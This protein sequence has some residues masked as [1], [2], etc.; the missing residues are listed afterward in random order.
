MKLESTGILINLRPFNENDSIACVFSY[1]FGILYGLLRGA[2]RSKKNRPLI[3]QIGHVSWNARLDSQFGVLHWEPEKN[4]TTN[5]ILNPKLLM[6]I[7]AL[8][9]LISTLLPEREPY[10]NLYTATLKFLQNIYFSQ[11]PEK[12]YLAWE[13]NLL[14]ELGYALDLTHCSGCGK[15]ENLNYL[16]PKTGRAVCTKCAQPYLTR[17]YTLPINLETSLY[18]INKICSQQSIKIPFSRNLLSNKKF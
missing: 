1:D 7:N 5:I 18:F 6:Y 8:F 11:Q 14:R 15:S 16:S 4:L 3:G 10:H 2:N 13:I 9:D 17:L 12:D